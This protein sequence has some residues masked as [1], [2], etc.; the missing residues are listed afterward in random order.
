MEPPG[1]EELEKAYREVTRKGQRGLSRGGGPAGRLADKAYS[2]AGNRG[3]LRQRGIKAVIPVKE[4]QQKHRRNQRRAGGQPSVFDTGW[5]AKRNTVECSLSK[6][7]QV[8][9][10]AYPF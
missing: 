8:R 5:Y 6:V 2:S 7:K 1:S 9:A 10:V 3:W 4:D